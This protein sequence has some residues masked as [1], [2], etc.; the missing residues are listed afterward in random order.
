MINPHVLYGA[1]DVG[2]IFLEL[3][4]RRMDTDHH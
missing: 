4:F 2:E 3:K 1:L